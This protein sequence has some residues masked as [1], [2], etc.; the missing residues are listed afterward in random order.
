MQARFENMREDLARDMK[1]Y[2]GR[3]N[4]SDPDRKLETLREI[5]ASPQNCFKRQAEDAPDG[6]VKRHAASGL[7][8]YHS[9]EHSISDMAMDR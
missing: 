8:A 1:N 9:R 5:T 2:Y 7:I 4:K 3:Q 6:D